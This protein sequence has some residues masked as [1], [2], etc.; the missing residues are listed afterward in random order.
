MW[1]VKRRIQS[2]QGFQEHTVECSS[3]APIGQREVAADGLQD[4]QWQDG[5]GQ[6]LC[7]SHSGVLRRQGCC[8]G[9][10][11]HMSAWARSDQRPLPGHNLPIMAR[12]V[13]L[14]APCGLCESSLACVAPVGSSMPQVAMFCW[15]DGRWAGRKPYTNW[16]VHYLC[17]CPPLL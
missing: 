7:C 6:V 3:T 15:S 12:H 16:N 2:V 17:F 8:S 14:T 10:L 11:Q 5:E 9:R 1:H 13:Y 4:I